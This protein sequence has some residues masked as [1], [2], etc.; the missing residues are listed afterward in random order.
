MTNNTAS[1][2][3]TERVVLLGLTALGVALLSLSFALAISSPLFGYDYLVRDMPVFWLAGSM[4]LAG[5]LF[6]ALLWLV[7]AASRLSTKT[8]HLLF[9]GVLVAGLLMRLVQFTAEPSLEDDF[10]RYL[11]DGAVTAHGL[12]PYA[13]SPDQAKEA[14]PSIFQIGRLGVESGLVLERVNH[15]HLRTIYPPVAQGA[16]ALSYMIGPWSINAWR[17]V[18]LFFDLAAVALLLLL[19]K[20]L[21][22]SPLWVS[23]YWWNPIAIKELFN[24]GH[25]EAVV[26]PFVLAGLVLTIR[27]RPIAATFS[28]TLAAGA[29]LWPVILLPLVWRSLMHD[30][31]KLLIAVGITMFSLALFAWPVLSAGLDPASGFVAYASKWKTNSALFPALESITSPTVARAMVATLLAIIIGWQYRTAASDPQD[32]VRRAFIIVSA[33]FLLSPAQFPWYFLWVLPLLCL[34]PVRGLLVLTATLPLYYTA[35]Y[36]LARGDTETFPATIVW[37]IW[38]PAWGMLLWQARDQIQSFVTARSRKTA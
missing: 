14:D 6:L 7:P 23:L 18:I 4:G 3:Q 27:K 25:M 24:A 1:E 8:T 35:F 36:F 38:L 33:L 5:A 30:P 20:D 26:I 15:P 17:L 21:G 12:N 9:W 32:I 10:Q 16:F 31:R 19:L 34:V 11:W 29:K 37:L 28:L 22:H 2:L 13:L